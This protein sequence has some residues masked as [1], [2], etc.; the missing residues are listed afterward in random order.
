MKTFRTNFD[1]SHSLPKSRRFI[2]IRS[3]LLLLGSCFSDNIGELLIKHKFKALSNPFGT[4]FNPLSIFKILSQILGKKSI[5]DKGFIEQH[6][7]WQHYDYHSSIYADSK[8]NLTSK[9]QEKIQD[10]RHFLDN[11]STFLIITLGTAWV[12]QYIDNQEFVANCHKLPT[13]LF[14]KQLLQPSQIVQ[15][16][17]NIY[18]FLPQDAQIIL[19]VSPVRH[20]KDTLPLNSVSKAVLR[21]ACHELTEKYSQNV[22]YFPSYELLLDDLRDYRFYAEDMIH[23]NEIAIEYIWESFVENMM[24]QE[25][26]NFIFEWKKILNSLNHRPLYSEKSI[27]HQTFLKNLL[28]KLQSINIVDLSKEI[29]TIKGK[30]IENYT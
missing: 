27:Q 12:Y 13:N 30:I 20:I 8:T 18:Q 11:N 28:D 23:P 1:I 6:G 24:N 22:I 10:S 14:K 15:G 5:D 25:T 26:K 7:F 9:I 17:E 19:T 3:N 29:E 16:F 4:I 2:D 21:I